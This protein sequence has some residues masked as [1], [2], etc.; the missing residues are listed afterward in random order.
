MSENMIINAL[1]LGLTVI[2]ICVVALNTRKHKH[3]QEA[4][5]RKFLD[6]EAAANQ[7]RKKEIDPQLY[8]TPD[9]TDLPPI[10]EDDPHKVIRA[11]ARQMI[12]F[13]KPVTNLELKN[14]YGPAQMD[15][16][17]LHE[18]NFNEYLK[19]L[20]AWATSLAETDNEQD[21]SDA[22]L[23]LGYAI[24]HGSE[25]RN[26]YKLTADIYARMGEKETLIALKETAE[27]NHFRDP[28][29]RHHIVEHIEK[30]IEGL[31]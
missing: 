4:L 25:F 2:V 14:Q 6:D 21:I 17:A 20:T 12:Y 16:I 3:K 15:L 7:V 30:K 11:A 26:T 1:I 24:A 29:I 18:E 10:E 13:K 27:I 28:A 31:G 9:L 23:I 5:N 19:A 22:L 8:F